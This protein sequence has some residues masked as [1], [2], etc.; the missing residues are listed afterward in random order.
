M[1]SV[2]IPTRN[3]SELLTRC[4]NAILD[5]S[6]K[7]NR[8][9]VIDSSDFDKRK[10]IGFLSDN[11]E[12]EFTEIKS[13]AKQRNI[14]LNKVDINCK[15]IAFIDDDVI[16]PENYF[17]DLISSMERYGYL[18]IS[19]L[20]I[21]IDN[22]LLGKPKS[23]IKK[24]I[25]QMFLLDSNANGVLLRSGVNIP[26]KMRS[27]NPVESEWLIGCSIWNYSKI[28]DLRF[29]EDF[30]GQSLGEDVIF[31]LKASKRGKIAVDTNVLL[32]H[33]ESP[34]V[35]PNREE[36]MSMWIRNRKR[37]VSEMETGYFKYLA[38]HWANFGKFL[39]IIVFPNPNKLLEVRGLLSGYEL[40]CRKNEN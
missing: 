26:I 16:I 20:A 2:I 9:I 8:I 25:S 6:I 22:N 21:N 30:Y 40:C 5:N 3:R 11:I 4:L 10:R 31:S 28:K 14:G 12:Q 19:G 32:N 29:E 18:G 39:Q 23:R 36:F 1:I 27:A 33:L 15:Y 37:I 24:L 7:P 38:F 35:R 34:I 17:T 13:A